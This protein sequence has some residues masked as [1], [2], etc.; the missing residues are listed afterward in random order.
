M[1]TRSKKWQILTGCARM[2]GSK[3]I[4][5]IRYQCCLFPKKIKEIGPASFEKSI[6]LVRTKSEVNKQKTKKWLFLTKCAKLHAQTHPDT[7][8]DR[9][10]H[11][12]THL[13]TFGVN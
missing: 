11:Q 7:H 13:C 12:Q 4:T 6:F 9:N 5:Q 10:T 1:L 8:T 3:Q 2:E